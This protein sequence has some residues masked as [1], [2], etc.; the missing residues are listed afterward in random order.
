M[1]LIDTGKSDFNQCWNDAKETQLHPGILKDQVCSPGDHYQR[2]ETLEEN[3]FR[4]A[5]LKQLKNQIK[6]L[7]SLFLLF[8]LLTFFCLDKRYDS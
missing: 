5:V 2:V 4:N 8:L 1:L 6:I 3:G 7:G